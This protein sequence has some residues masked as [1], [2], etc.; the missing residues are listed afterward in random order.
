MYV[1]MLLLHEGSCLLEACKAT[2]VVSVS[3]PFMSSLIILILSYVH[4]T[5]LPCTIEKKSVTMPSNGLSV[6]TCL[7]HQK[8]NVKVNAELGSMSFFSNLIRLLIK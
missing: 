1:E 4:E 2:S 3:L 7:K 8:D 6:F 5:C